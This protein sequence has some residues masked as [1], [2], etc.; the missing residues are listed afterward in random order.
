MGDLRSTWFPMH[1]TAYGPPKYSGVIWVNRTLSINIGACWLVCTCSRCSSFEGGN[2]LWGASYS[3]DAISE[4][5]IDLD[6]LEDQATLQ[7]TSVA[8]SEL[9]L[10]SSSD[11]QWINCSAGTQVPLFGGEELMWV[12]IWIPLVGIFWQFGYNRKS[13]YGLVETW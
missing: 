2:S 13:V 9:S 3:C 4:L 6:Q 12:E 8:T 10:F 5:H 1:P 11:D 7:F